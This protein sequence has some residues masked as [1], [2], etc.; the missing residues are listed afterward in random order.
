M[1][2]FDV[3]TNMLY[4]NGKRIYNEPLSEVAE[5]LEFSVE[6]DIYAD[7]IK[8]TRNWQYTGNGVEKEILYI[9]HGDIL[10]KGYSII[11]W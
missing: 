9:T 10:K 11:Q 7:I 6:T 8:K 5:K 1:K 3:R 2:K 4:T